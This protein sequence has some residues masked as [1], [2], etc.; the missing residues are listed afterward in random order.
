LAEWLNSGDV[1]CDERLMELNFGEWEQRRWDDIGAGELK[2]WTEDFV[3]QPCP[4]GESYR[5]QFHRAVAFWDELYHRSHDVVFIITHAG[6]IRALLAHLL[7]LPL[8]K[9]L[10][11]GLDFGGVIKIHMIEDVPIIDYINR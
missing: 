7:G 2:V 11:I 6:F 1:E 10:R 5:E 4:D 9:S 3:D 8:E